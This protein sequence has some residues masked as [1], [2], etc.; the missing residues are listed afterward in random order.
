MKNQFRMFVILPLL[1]SCALRPATANLWASSTVE[2]PQFI[3]RAEAICAG[4][5]TEVRP[6]GRAM[7]MPVLI[8]QTRTWEAET[9]IGEFVVEDVLKGQLKRP[10]ISVVFP[11][12]YILPDQD[13][14]TGL[15]W[16]PSEPVPL[17][18]GER[19]IL[20]LKSSGED[21]VWNV[22]APSNRPRPRIPIED[23][24]LEAS[25]KQLPTLRRLLVY[26]ARAL[27]GGNTQQ[28]HESLNHL[29]SLSLYLHPARKS[30][31][32]WESMMNWRAAAQEPVEAG[33]EDWVKQN[34][35]PALRKLADS[36]KTMRQSALYIAAHLQ[37]VEA[38]KSLLEA[39]NPSDSS[40]SSAHYV[41]GHLRTTEATEFLISV[42][43]NRKLGW[44]RPAAI[45]LG[46]ITDARSVPALLEALNDTNAPTRAFI[47]DALRLITSV[48]GPTSSFQ[49]QPEQ[50]EHIDFWNDWAME[51]QAQLQRWRDQLKVQTAP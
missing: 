34:V 5:V 47:I 50:Q 41:L 6:A 33:L 28:Q 20:F 11:I 30:L 23:V 3:E 46:N 36:D 14:K 8:G 21:G 32:S 2:L 9:G 42:L 38:A 27:N 24:S 13:R 40:Y 15:G 17:A 51:N 12:R 45:A 18:A 37:D 25:E 19:V 16:Q 44:E 48:D 26:L 39:A 31:L 7:V 49:E 29:Y 10:K 43:K 1:L 22:L 35:R 4:T